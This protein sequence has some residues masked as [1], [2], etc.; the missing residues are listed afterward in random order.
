MSKFCL[1]N[2]LS[3]THSH[4]GTWENGREAISSYNWKFNSFILFLFSSFF[5]S[6]SLLSCNSLVIQNI[7]NN[8]SLI[9]ILA[10]YSTQPRLPALGGW[11]EY[12]LASATFGMGNSRNL[13]ISTLTA[14]IFHGCPPQWSLS[15]CGF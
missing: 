2:V 1:C 4:Y 13:C 8:T 14:Q 11:V 5:L 3:V 6:L 12:S 7:E 10:G 9:L 15:S